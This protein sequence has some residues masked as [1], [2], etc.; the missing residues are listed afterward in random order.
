VAA[1]DWAGPLTRLR[2]RATLLVGAATLALA[3]AACTSG[4]STGSAAGTSASARGSAGKTTGSSTA[5]AA[6]AGQPFGPGCA[7]VPAA[8]PGSFAAIAVVPVGTAA[9]AE[10]QLS[11]LVRAVTAA[12]L[13]ESLNSQQNVTVFAP[14]DSA[15]QAIPPDQLN[16][17]L[18]DVPRLTAVLTHHVVQG[19]LGPDKLSGKHTTLDNDVVSVEGAGQKFTVPGD[20]TLTGKPANVVC[21]NVQTANA[22]VYLIDQVLKPQSTG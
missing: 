15:F 16:P 5:S 21:G 11:G 9:A 4:G 19:R 12:N 14:V 1:D 10:P 3:A 13:V 8:G 6:A 2:R 7:A 22:T 17:L 20:Q 18:A